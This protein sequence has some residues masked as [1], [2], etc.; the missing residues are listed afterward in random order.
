MNRRADCSDPILLSERQA[1]KRYS[2]EGEAA[3]PGPSDHACTTTTY[4]QAMLLLSLHRRRQS[5][6]A[7]HAQCAVSMHAAAGSPI[8][9]PS[10]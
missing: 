9:T 3:M 8:W 2:I 7:P 4:S 1:G 10:A 6:A 5:S